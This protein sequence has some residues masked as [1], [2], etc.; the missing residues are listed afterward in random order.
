MVNYRNT[1]RCFLVFLF[2]CILAV[3]LAEIFVRLFPGRF[4]QYGD[5]WARYS[6]GY[7]PDIGYINESNQKA[8]VGSDCY[9][10]YP[11]YTNSSGFRDREWLNKPEFKIALLG[12]SYVAA[13]ENPEDA[14]PSDIMEKILNKRV[15]NAGVGGHGTISELIVYRKF[16]RPL[17]PDLV[18]LYFLGSNDL[19]D[20][21]CDYTKEVGGVTDCKP[22][23][24]LVNG[25][26]EINTQFDNSISMKQPVLSPKNIRRL[27]KQTCYSCNVLHR[28]VYNK[29]ILEREMSQQRK[30]ML[31][32]YYKFFQPAKDKI[33]EDAWE[34]TE[35]TLVDLKKEIEKDGGKLIVV[36]FID[37]SR[38]KQDWL[39]EYKKVLGLNQLP[40]GFDADNPFLRL[41]EIMQR[42]G[43]NYLELEPYFIKYR[44]KFNLSRP[45]FSYWCDNHWS[46]L[47]QFIATNIVARYLIEHDL[48]PLS[49]RERSG[50]LRKIEYNLNLS[51][52]E[53]LG[54]EGYRQIYRRGFY[55]G[56]SNIDKILQ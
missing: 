51:P 17:K 2:G 50:L 32:T 44:N 1:F 45:Y 42:Q 53:I 30:K 38:F 12:D 33:W 41:R 14:S 24:N 10:I 40:D 13:I 34:I 48:I 25:R 55:R 39:F 47:G 11:V 7:D 22:C 4:M 31:M 5:Y 27:I 16:L 18:I 49:S 20:N 19:S 8:F 36:G 43:I 56:S 37:A 54:K 21:S 9:F 28:F 46:P 23:A 35:A 26:L 6:Y 52:E 29:L 15:F 3:A